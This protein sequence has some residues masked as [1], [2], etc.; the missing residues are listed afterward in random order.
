MTESIT[1]VLLIVAGVFARTLLPYLM[2]L[3]ENHNQPFDKKFL[4]PAGVSLVVSL[5][6]VPFIMPS[7][8]TSLPWFSIYSTA[9]TSSYILNDLARMAQKLYESTRE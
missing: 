6:L 1:T 4:I 8:D 5:I 9:F 3:I 2:M 7:I